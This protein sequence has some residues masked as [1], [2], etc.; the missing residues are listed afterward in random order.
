M[1]LVDFI[2]ILTLLLTG[3][4]FLVFIVLTALKR[5]LGWPFWFVLIAL[6]VLIT[7]GTVCRLIGHDPI[8][9]QSQYMHLLN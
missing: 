2:A 5:P 8:L 1:H 7:T 4:V 3:A 6:G 9:W